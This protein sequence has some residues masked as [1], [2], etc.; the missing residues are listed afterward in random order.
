ML[1]QASD[2]TLRY[3]FYLPTNLHQFLVVSCLAHYSTLK[4]EMMFS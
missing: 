3:I 4:T 2:C 1:T